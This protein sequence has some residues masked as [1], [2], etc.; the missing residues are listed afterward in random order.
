MENTGVKMLA[1]NQKPLVGSLKML[2]ICE[3]NMEY[4]ALNLQLVKE[5]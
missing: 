3:D 4:Y 2:C 5:F 1:F